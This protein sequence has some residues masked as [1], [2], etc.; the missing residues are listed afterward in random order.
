MPRA[1]FE[2]LLRSLHLW[3]NTAPDGDKLYI[4]RAFV[5]IFNAN[6]ERIYRPGKEVVIDEYL[7]PF[8]GPVAFRQYI[9][10]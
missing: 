7:A 9:P 10:S 3:D 5:E 2:E 4:M 6:C 8:R 1:R